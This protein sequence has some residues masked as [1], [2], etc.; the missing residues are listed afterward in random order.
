MRF[1]FVNPFYPL[2]EMPSPP[3]GVGYLTASLQRAN[4]EVRVYDLVVTRYDPSKLETI[5][6]EFQPDIVGATAVSMTLASALDVLAAAKRIDPRVVT[7]LGGAHV[8]FRAE[9]TLAQQ[10]AL[11]VAALGEGEETIVELCEAVAGKR[12]LASVAGL[13]FRDGDAIRMSSPRTTWVDVNTLPLPAR[14]LTPLARYRALGTPIS[15]TT[16]RGCPFQCIFCVGR[17]LVGAK[18]RWRDASSVVDEMQQLVNLG[19]SQINLADDLF[20]AKHSH[21]LAVCDEILRRGLRVSWVSF[22]NV[23]TVDVP[24]LR[25]MKEAGCTTVSFG[26]ESGNQEILKTTK[27][28][29]RISKIREAVAACNEAGVRASGSFIVGLPGETPETIAQTIA[30]GR[31]LK[32]LGADTGF[33]MLAPFP[34]TAVREQADKYQL[35]IFTDDWSQYNANHA[36]T[37]TPGADRATQE[38]IATQF[39]GAAQKLFWDLAARV[40]DGTASVEERAR[41]ASVERHGIYHDLMMHDLLETRGSFRTERS[42]LSRAQAVELLCAEVSAATGRPPS[43]VRQALDHGLDQKLLHYSSAFGVC[44]WRFAD[45]DPSLLVTE[46][47]RRAPLLPAQ[48]AQA[49]PQTQALHETA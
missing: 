48:R 37:E 21:A 35:K 4:V 36:I 19:F 28:G 15:M 31:E 25:R 34:G 32:E 46:S 42:E 43:V 20:T 3:L 30:L 47:I 1:L 8:S 22:A 29:T 17:K 33:H 6:A 11:D 41:Y 45:A 27:K 26:L 16:S 44:S 9:Q 39:E 12:T 10:P 7:V 24:V 13:C 18:I 40:Q 49:H 14:E 2:S 5:M 38:V 23:N